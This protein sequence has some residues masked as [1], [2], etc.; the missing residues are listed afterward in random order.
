M[1]KNSYP[2]ALKAPLALALLQQQGTLDRKARKELDQHAGEMLRL[3][4]ESKNAQDAA[5]FIY[6]HTLH[7]VDNTLTAAE[8][9]KAM[10]S[11]FAPG[12]ELDELD[13]DLRADFLD[14]SRRIAEHGTHQIMARLEW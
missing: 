10:R 6:I 7:K 12:S 4:M 2:V 1:A 11:P 9:I 8:L 3:A 5:A 13:A 14:K